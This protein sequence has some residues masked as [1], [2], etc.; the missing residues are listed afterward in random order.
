ME[1]TAEV[2]SHWIAPLHVHHA[3]DEAWYVLAGRL[4]FRLDD[5]ELSAGPGQAVLASRGVA[6]TFWNAGDEEARYLLVLTPRIAHLI[7]AIH[8]PGADIAAAFAAHD[9]ELLPTS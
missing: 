9:S 5:E 8:A 1:W 6:H 4:G 2:G 7:D 3:D